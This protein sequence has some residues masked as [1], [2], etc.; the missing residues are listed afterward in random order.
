MTKFYSREHLN[1]ILFNVHKV[2]SL[3]THPKF[4]D[5]NEELFHMVLDSADAFAKQKM[6]PLHMEMDSDEPYLKDGK[7]HVHPEM[8]R[9]TREFAEQGWI[10]STATYKEG[11]QQLPFTLAQAA[12]F[13]MAAANYS[14]VAYPGL[15]QGAS[16]LIRLFG[17][18][19]QKSTYVPKMFGGSWQGT[20]AMTEP[21]AGS[22]LSDITTTAFRTNDDHFII[23]GQKIFISCGD[24]DACD[25][26]VHLMLARINGAAAGVKGISLFIV[27]QKRVTTDGSLENNDVLTAGLYHKLGYR[28]APIAHLMMGENDNCYGF[29]VGEENQGLRYMFRMMNGARVGVGLHA[30]SI[31]SAA[32]YASLE[33]SK[34][35][36]QGRN[37]ANK[38]ISLPQ[39]PIIQHA[40]VKRMLLFQKSIIE[41]SASLLM[42]CAMYED[43]SFLGDEATREKYALMLDLLTPIAKT[44]PSE[45]GILSTSAALQIHGGYGYT[46]DFQAEKYFREIRIHTLHEGTTAMHGMDLL[47]R[48]VIMKNG[49]ALMHLMQNVMTDIE[50]A[51]QLEDLNDKAEKL[52]K[53]VKELQQLTMQLM[54]TAQK[55]GP[56]V[57][58]SD[59]TLFLELFSIITIAWQWLKMNTVALEEMETADACKTTFLKSNLLT[60][61]YYFEYELPKV[62]GLLV[63]LKSSNHLTV[64]AEEELLM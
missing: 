18:E 5:H 60:G 34:E 4:S 16:E 55:D 19:E 7:I 28:G 64:D 46:R 14:A 59:A 32:Y 39:V 10:S 44:Y 52:Y 21:D 53:Q 1:F 13:I 41:G 63:R 49:Q 36:K 33:Y 42:L 22:S 40:D 48:K 51:R 25:N 45:M 6:Y 37:I 56:E 17:S 30:T 57:F 12:S 20:M 9:L 2:Q 27:P 38:D 61:D 8:N 62:A 43:L 29:L 23:K 58:L 24:H 54:M 35:R 50:K 47:G 26:V 11:G 15:T 31:A 3:C